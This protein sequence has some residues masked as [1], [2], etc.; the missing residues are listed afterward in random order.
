[1]NVPSTQDVFLM[2]QPRHPERCD[3][4]SGESGL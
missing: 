3:R 2:V 1:M 4:I